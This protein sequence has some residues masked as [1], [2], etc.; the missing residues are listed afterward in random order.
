MEGVGVWGKLKSETS[1]I[2]S[3][4]DED[5]QRAWQWAGPRQPESRVQ[6]SQ[7]SVPFGSRIGWSY[8]RKCHSDPLVLHR[9]AWKEGASGLHCVPHT[10]MELALP[11][12]AVAL[13]AKPAGS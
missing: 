1:V 7:R 5:K 10:D 9:V 11:P 8:T 6:G 12:R 2:L 13:W 3:T 4:P